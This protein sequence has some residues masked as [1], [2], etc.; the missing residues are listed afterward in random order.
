M[1]ANFE[2]HQI[3]SPTNARK[4]E[5]FNTERDYNR[6]FSKKKVGEYS[7]Y[8]NDIIGSGYSSHVYRCHH[9]SNPNI[10]YAIKVIKLSRLA[11]PTLNLLHNEIKILQSLEHPNII[12]FHNFYFTENNCYLV[13]DYCEGGTLQEHIDKGRKLDHEDI[14]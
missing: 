10:T 4:S 6:A 5:S 3:Q 7:Y 8:L 1:F 2:G 9:Q 12:K 13:T 14:F 11:K